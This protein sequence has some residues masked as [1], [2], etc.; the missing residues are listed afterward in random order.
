MMVSLD[1]SSSALYV[2]AFGELVESRCRWD[3]AG[4]VAQNGHA[5]T[6]PR[7]QPLYRS[8]E[9]PAYLMRILNS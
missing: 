7:C 3:A 1:I 5:W 4:A 6:P 8:V 2:H 9:N